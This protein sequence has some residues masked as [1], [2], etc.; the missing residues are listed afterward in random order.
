MNRQ[1]DIADVLGEM[2]NSKALYANS[3]HREKPSACLV[4]FAA[5]G[6]TLEV[7]CDAR[8]L[9]RARTTLRRYAKELGL[10]FPDY[11]PRGGK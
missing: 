8:H 5:K 2:Q 9:N 11:K 7:C 4:H 10:T 1:S 6:L 3:T